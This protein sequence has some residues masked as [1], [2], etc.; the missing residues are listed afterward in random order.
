MSDVRLC[1]PLSVTYRTG[2]RHQKRKLENG[3]QRLAPEK[4]ASRT[5]SLEIS[6]QR[7]GHA[8]L[9][10]WNIRISRIPWNQQRRDRTGWL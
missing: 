9:T 6:L 8:S 10:R 1:E 7:L 5:Q 2:L 4:H 3:E